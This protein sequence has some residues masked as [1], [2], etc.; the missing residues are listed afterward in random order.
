MKLGFALTPRESPISTLWPP[1]AI[2]LAV[3][4]FVSLR[5]WWIP[6]LAVLP[7]HLLFQHNI[8]VPITTS[9]GWYMGNVGEA[10]VGAACI[11]RFVTPAKMFDSIR[12]VLIFLGFGAVLA[13]LVTTFLDVAAVVFSGWGEGYWTLWWARFL[14][15]ALAELIFVPLIVSFW[16]SARSWIRRSPPSYYLEALLLALSIVVTTAVVFEGKTA[17]FYSSAL[18]Y[19]PLS[20][21][22]WAALRFGLGGLS[23]SLLTVALLSIEGTLHRRGPFTS[24]S[25]NVNV[26]SL[27][28]LLCTVAT[29]LIVLT[30]LIAERREMEQSLRELAHRLIGTQEQERKRIARELHDDVGQ[31]LALVS[32]G[33]EQLKNE[34]GTRLRPDVSRLAEQVEDASQSTRELSHGLHPAYL[35]YVGLECAIRRLCLDIGAR[36]SLSIRFVAEHLDRS[37][38]SE[39]SLC[40]YR[41]AQEALQNVVRHSGASEVSVSLEGNERRILLRIIDNGAG[42]VSKA[43]P[44][45]GIGLVGMRERLR[46]V[47]GDVQITSQPGRGTTVEATVS[48]PK[49]SAWF[50][51]GD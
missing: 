15:N 45:D 21:L 40:L 44:Q 38:P 7:T 33:L 50:W 41:I 18:A 14:S 49:T 27:Q 22:L 31:Q 6:A 4:L 16:L 25:L 43:A 46:T 1:N 10:L 13:P 8:G 24:A 37:L 47:N 26:V 11:R 42:F 30:G 20:L 23:V 28:V 29:P 19:V 5:R 2:L 35:E 48:L 51:A 3:F 9:L 17:S 12:G 34:V 32:V 39:V 36:K